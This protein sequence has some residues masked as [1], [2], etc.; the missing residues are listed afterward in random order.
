MPSPTPI[1]VREAV[2]QRWQQGQASSE[3]ALKDGSCVSW[4][5]I[6][7]EYTGAMLMPRVFSKA[8]FHSVDPHLVQQCIRD[9]MGQWAEPKQCNSLDALQENID[10]MDRLQREDYQRPGGGSRLELFPDLLHSGRGY[11]PE[12]EMAEWDWQRIGDHLWCYTVTRLVDSSGLS[13]IYNHL[14]Y[15]GRNYYK[16]TVHVSF[17]P[18]TSEWLFRDD[19]GLLLRAHRGKELEADK[20][21]SLDVT[22]RRDRGKTKMSDSTPKTRRPVTK[23]PPQR[24]RRRI[25]WLKQLRSEVLLAHCHF[26]T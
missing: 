24:P 21:I 25:L 10:Q 11:A 18:T 12:T 16:Q 5:R 20:I 6:V 14:Y 19:R 2:H 15:V 8:R 9:T 17:D 3:I 4:L 7:D 22:H 23:T 1:P 13:S 26:T